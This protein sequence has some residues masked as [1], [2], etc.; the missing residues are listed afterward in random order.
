[1]GF[2]SFFSSVQIYRGLK[3][4]PLKKG[5]KRKKMEKMSCGEL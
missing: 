2:S 5:R 3:K 1:M 4:R